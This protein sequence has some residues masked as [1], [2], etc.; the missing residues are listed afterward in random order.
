MYEFIA[1]LKKRTIPPQMQAAATYDEWT[2]SAEAYDRARG[3]DKWKQTDKSQH[4]DHRFIRE[5]LELIRA[6]I[7][8]C[9]YRN[10]M[11][12]LEVD[13]PFYGS[14]ICRPALYSKAMFG[15]KQLIHDYITTVCNAL[16]T[17]LTVESEIIAPVEKTK[18]FRRVS[19]SCGHSALM[20]SGGAV[21]GFF[22][23]GVMKALFEQNLLPRVISGSSAGS[24]M[25]AVA[26]THS[27]EQLRDRLSLK[28]LYLETD[29][30]CNVQPEV[31]LMLKDD[32][33]MDAERLGIYLENI[34]PDMT[35]KEAEEVSGRSLNITVT[36]LR[37][38]QESLLLNPISA[39]HVY[40]RSAVM[41]SCAIYGIYPPV[42]LV[43]KNTAGEHVDYLP[44]LQWIDG[45]FVDD[46]PAKRLARLYGINHF[47]SSMTNPAALALTP[48]PDTDKSLL[49]G[50]LN[51][52]ARVFKKITTETLKL[53]RDHLRIKSPIGSLLQHLSYSVL[54]QEYTADINIFLRNRCDHP[55]RLLD[56]PSREEMKRL[57]HEGERATWEKIEM[58]RD[59]TAISRTLEGILR[60]RVWN[61][62]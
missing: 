49:G 9:E 10:L 8:Q 6:L 16:K 1:P 45:S 18:F 62:G 15:T 38:N 58:V 57:I 31:S 47:I 13:I 43:G 14:H 30:A 35:F 3:L 46:L 28:R 36:G 29:T 32:S 5:R 50:L 21:L 60:T 27:D 42:T 7:D 4:Y 34:I 17:L 37:P 26:C 22:H 55:L 48:D 12:V 41:A 52:H 19:L 53:S 40:V 23:A 59:C 20:L 39:P 25:A 33:R 54:A 56:T 61:K 44:H 51:C 2:A 11:A 24:I